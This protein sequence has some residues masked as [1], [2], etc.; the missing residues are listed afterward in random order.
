M[1]RFLV[2]AVLGPP[3]AALTLFLLVLPLASLVH[4][5]GVDIAV[6]GWFPIYLGSVFPALV[7]A[8]FD[9]LAE[10]IDLPRRPIGTAIAGWAL[11]AFSLSDWLALPGND[12]PGWIVAIGLLGAIPAF[13]CSWVTIR[14]KKA[15]RI[16][17]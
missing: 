15:Q 13:I 9:W 5:R 2:F 12:V 7:L 10:V 4:G 14:M 11:A 6:P 1:R 8:F 17:A 3:L 16:S